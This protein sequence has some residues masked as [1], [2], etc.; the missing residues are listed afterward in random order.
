M[1]RPFRFLVVRAGGRERLGEL[2]AAFVR[3][4]APDA[5]P[6]EIDKQR[7]A[8]TRAPVIVV[9]AAHV[10]PA[11]PKIPEVEQ[12]AAVA[13]ATQNMLLA[14][15]A[16][17]FAAKWATGKQAYDATVKE[18]SA[19]SRPTGSSAFSISGSPAAAHEARARPG[20][21]DLVRMAA[22]LTGQILLLG[23]PA[24]PRRSRLHDA[25]AGNAGRG[26]DTAPAELHGSRLRGGHAGLPPVPAPAADQRA[27]GGGRAPIDLARAGFQFRA[28]VFRAG[29]VVGATRHPACHPNVPYA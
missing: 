24:D 2:F 16:L 4:T 20:F 26:A 28:T 9:V 14:A 18:S 8:P 25:A 21:D 12:I 3:R 23:G 6:A 10:D 5:S 7:T 11:H 13:A 27:A 1:L 17:G 15:H 19:W 29:L 22:R